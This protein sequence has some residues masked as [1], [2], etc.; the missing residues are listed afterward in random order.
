MNKLGN[1]QYGHLTTEIM[2]ERGIPR[3]YDCGTMAF[4]M[5]L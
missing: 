1:N 3:I 4:E 5:K 2:L